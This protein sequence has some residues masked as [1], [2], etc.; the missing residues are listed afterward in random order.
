MRNSSHKAGLTDFL[1]QQ[2]AQTTKKLFS[3]NFIRWLKALLLPSLL[4][5][6]CEFLVRNGDIEAYL[7]P[8]PSSLWQSFWDLAQSD[9]LQHIYISTW[10]VLVGFALGSGLALIFAIWVG[11]SKEVE[12]YLE[13]TFSALKSIPSLAWIPLLLLW[14]GIDESSKITLIAIGAFF[15]TYTNTVAAIHNVDRK[16]IE[17]GKVYRLNALQRVISIVLPAASSG[18]LTGLRNSLS[19][20]WMFMIAAELIAATQGIGYLLS[21]GRE[22]SRPDIVIIAIILLALL[23]KISD[24]LMKLLENRLLRWRDT[25]HKQT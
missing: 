11:L 13:P 23:G 17:V 4:L 14:L 6:L 21:D 3:P 19:L 20:S 5:I 16:L 12:A 1:A 2:S 22:T 10:R 25:I 7:L 24:S 9:L 8:A 18:I 15:P